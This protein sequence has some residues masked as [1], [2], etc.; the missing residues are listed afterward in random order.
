MILGASE[1]GVSA[2][3][4]LGLQVVVISPKGASISSEITSQVEG[5]FFVESLEK[6]ECVFRQVQKIKQIYINI[7]LILSFTELGLETAAKISKKL[8]LPTNEPSVIQATRNKMMMRKKFQSRT[9]LSL[10][11]QSGFIKE[12]IKELPMKPPFI[13]KPLDGFGSK[14]IYYISSAKEWL[15]WY[16][17]QQEN[18]AIHWIIEPYIKGKEYS[19]ESIS[20]NDN[21]QILGITEKTT[22][23]KPHFVETGHSVPANLSQ[24]EKQHIEEI[25]IEALYCL[26]V[27]YGPCHTE[28]KYDKMT[29]QVSIIEVHTR[30]GGDFIPYL[31]ELS[32]GLN[33]YELGIQSYY[34]S[35]CISLE[36]RK[37]LSYSMIEFFVFPEGILMEK[38]LSFPMQKEYT[39]AL[40]IYYNIGD[41]IKE[42]VDSCSRG[43]HVIVCSSDKE[44]SIQ[45]LQECKENITLKIKNK[46]M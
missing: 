21:H 9:I 33:Q 46:G 25:V 4:K 36:M 38:G 27:R 5:V 7:D 16:E 22:T 23:G 13:V 26:D 39:K 40:D 2:G 34:S 20:C 43:G 32:S 10:A 37:K 18:D 8:G 35:E 12:F 3:K 44:K 19:V 15:N 41:E 30:P 11:F 17:E 42:T 24:E 1:Y 14:N 28:V 31:H 6:E 29:N 45:L